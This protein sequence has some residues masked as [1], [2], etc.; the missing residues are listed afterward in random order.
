[1]STSPLQGVDC[2]LRGTHEFAP[3]ADHAGRARFL[4]VCTFVFAALYGMVM[5]S[6]G[7]LVRGEVRLLL[8]PLIVALKTPALLLITF[9]LCVPSF[10]VINCLLGLREDFGEALRAVVST[11]ACLSIIL[12]S[13]IPVTLFFYFC[14]DYYDAAILFNG[15]VFAIACFGSAVVLKRYYGPLIQRSG[16]HRLALIAWFLLY[17]FVAIQ[18]AWTLRPFIGDPNPDVA[19]VIFRS[20][21]IDNAYLE[22]IRLLDQVVQKWTELRSVGY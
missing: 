19:V 20:G 8:Y 9:A 12:A 13:F 22:V 4:L 2:F 3:E 10:Y 15:G 1:M 21:D 16:R 5:G 17:A 14:T 18:M 7:F 11:L 6:F